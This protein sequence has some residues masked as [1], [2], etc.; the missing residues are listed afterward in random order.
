VNG[1]QALLV[2]SHLSHLSSFIIIHHLLRLHQPTVSRRRLRPS[3]RSFVWSDMAD[4]QFSR[5]ESWSRDVSRPVLT[6][7]GLGTW[8][9]GVLVFMKREIETKQKN[10][11]LNYNDYDNTV[12]LPKP[13]PEIVVYCVQLPVCWIFCMPWLF[14]CHSPSQSWT[15]SFGRVSLESRSW[16]WKSKSW[17]WSWCWNCWVLVLVLDKQALNPSLDIGTMISHKRFTIWWNW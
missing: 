17:S 13:L 5:L 8:D 9:H 10:H 7:L 4:L 11:T 15:S 6:S 16:S 2:T 1:R 12:I 14:V 3:V